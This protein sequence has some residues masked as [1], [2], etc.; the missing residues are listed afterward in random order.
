[1]NK[2]PIYDIIKIINDIN[3]LKILVIGDA[4][5]DEYIYVSYLGKPSKKILFQHYTKT[6]KIKQEVY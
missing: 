1:M 5:I 6:K 4:I 3:K 2:Y